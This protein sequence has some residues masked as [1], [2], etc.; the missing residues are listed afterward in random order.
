MVSTA[1]WAI[2]TIVCVEKWLS[3]S[4]LYKAEIKTLIIANT[5]TYLPKSRAS[6]NSLEW[7]CTCG[8]IEFKQ[9]NIL[10][11]IAQKKTQTETNTNCYGA[12][13]EIIK[14]NC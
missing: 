9:N 6:F 13:I 3:A 7:M 14:L 1:Q 2:E 4:W 10:N 11:K 5:H 8:E 12:A